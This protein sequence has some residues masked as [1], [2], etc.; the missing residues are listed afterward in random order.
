MKKIY[1]NTLFLLLFP[2]LSLAN[3]VLDAE[4]EYMITCYNTGR[5][6]ISQVDG[7][8]YPLIYNTNASVTTERVF[9]IIK[10]ESPGKYSFKNATTN[11]YIRF[12]PENRTGKYVT[13][14]DHLEGDNVLFTIQPREK[15]GKTYYAVNTVPDPEHYFNKRADGSVGTFKGSNGNSDNE[16]YYF[17]EKSEITEVGTGA[18]LNYLNSFTLNQKELIASKESL[19]YFSIP[20]NPEETSVTLTIDFE[21]KNPDHTIKIN[22]ETV[23]TGQEVVFENA[24]NIAG[25][26]IDILQDD[27]IIVSEKLIFTSLP[28]VQLYTNG[29]YL[30][31]NFSKGK[32][33]VHEGAKT[34]TQTG[35]LLNSEMRY[36]GA[37]AMNYEK[38]AFAIK[39]K[40][41]ENNSL[42]RSFFGLR[43]D[44]YWIL[45]A[46]AVDRSRMRNRVCTDLWNDFSA[47][48]YYKAEEENMING[49]RGHFVE[50]FLDDEYWGIY[51]MTERIDR[52]QL[53]LKKYQEETDNIR[54][55]LY[56]SGKWTYS[57]MM[58]WIPDRGPDLSYRLPAFDNTEVEWDGY[59]VK[60]PDLEDGERVD[61]QPLYDA[62]TVAGKY[63]ATDF[64]NNVEDMFDLPVWADYY[65][66]IELVLATDNHG[67]NGYFSI[68]NTQEDMKMLITPWD[69]DGTFGRQWGGRETDAQLNFVEY[70]TRVE[71]GE[72]NLIRR[73]RDDNIAG[74]A[75]LLKKRYDELRFTW[76]SAESLIDRFETY[77]DM[78]ENSGAATRETERWRNGSF[79]SE[80]AY[81]DDWIRKRVDFLNDQYGEPIIDPDPDPDPG[82][83]TDMDNV[84]FSLKVYPNPVVD[85]LYI[86]DLASNSRVY[87]YTTTGNCV[88]KNEN[89]NTTSI[90]IDFSNY[91]AGLYFLKVGEE[92]K[93][94]IKK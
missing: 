51:C 3:L 9:W 86:K 25:H 80:R 55:V 90:S 33:C 8:M 71:H 57:T 88:Y 35:E 10:E 68:Y 40:D 7:G 56:K 16:L 17:R 38:K 41:E 81:L 39:L 91:P 19:Y 82:P 26:R 5:G 43:N 73:L 79:S 45:D 48:P 49:T 66:L 77:M 67:K 31:S 4:G 11:Q 53:K 30:S 93:V 32:I 15:D 29:S 61:W 21:A 23:V 28:I 76:F 46:A 52:K 60:Y 69:L 2:L 18:L 36:R 20:Y 63:S 14:T 6:G 72:N 59:E 84:E 34:S 74:F 65:L 83:G 50:V 64:K 78:F 62:V 58:G 44:N 22:N 85:V 75:D 89:T 27:K 37:T 24:T 42:D 54:G 13:M 94:I 70:T 47:D 87:V 92:G 12:T 1:F